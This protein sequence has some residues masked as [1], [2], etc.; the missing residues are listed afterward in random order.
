MS[1]AALLHSILRNRPLVDG[2]KRF[3]WVACLAFL[4]VNGR[5]FVPDPDEATEFVLAVAA[6][7]PDDLSKIAGRLLDWTG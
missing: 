7:E 5:T 4:A 1:A 6:G 2:N 3:A